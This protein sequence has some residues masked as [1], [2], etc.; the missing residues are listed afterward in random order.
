MLTCW[1]GWR[2]R[3]FGRHLLATLKPVNPEN[4]PVLDPG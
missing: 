4:E 1:R 3:N 2:R